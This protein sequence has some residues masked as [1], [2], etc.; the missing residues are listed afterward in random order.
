MT[1][2]YIKTILRNPKNDKIAGKPLGFLINPETTP[3]FFKLALDF[4]IISFQ[5]IFLHKDP[6]IFTN[7]IISKY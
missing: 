7:F 6:Q 3:T 1:F 2:F 5:S 4:T